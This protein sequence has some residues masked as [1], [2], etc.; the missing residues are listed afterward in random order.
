MPP[1]FSWMPEGGIEICQAVKP[2]LFFLGNMPA[3]KDWFP[4]RLLKTLLRNTFFHRVPKSVIASFRG[5]KFHPLPAQDDEGSNHCH[6]RENTFDFPENTFIG[7]TRIKYCVEQ[8][9]IPGLSPFP[10]ANHPQIKER[11]THRTPEGDL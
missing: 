3:N 10:D 1:A 7:P 4:E 5:L 6:C 2:F 8:E 11:K 9:R